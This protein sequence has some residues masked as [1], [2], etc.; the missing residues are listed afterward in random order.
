MAKKT[1]SAAPAAQPTFNVAVI[2]AG[3]VG[4]DHRSSLQ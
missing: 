4:Y 1:A 2:G 3:A